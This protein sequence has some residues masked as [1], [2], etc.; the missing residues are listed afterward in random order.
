M[1]DAPTSDRWNLICS[2]Q[3][4]LLTPRRLL[5]DGPRVA[6]ESAIG[7]AAKN[8]IHVWATMRHHRSVRQFP[9]GLEVWA[10]EEARIVWAGAGVTFSP[11]RKTLEKPMVMGPRKIPR[12]ANAMFL[13]LEKMVEELGAKEIRVFGAKWRNRSRRWQFHVLRAAYQKAS[14]HGIKIE[15]MRVDG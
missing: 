1:A 15:I 8:R 13:A 9:P 6:I 10:P 3:Y 2:T 12:P 5:L 11:L 4:G 7:Y 14:L